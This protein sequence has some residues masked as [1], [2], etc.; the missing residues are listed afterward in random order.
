[1]EQ[2]N[3]GWGTTQEV[4][5]SSAWS[6]TPGTSV[7]QTTGTTGLERNQAIANAWDNNTPLPNGKIKFEK[8]IMVIHALDSDDKLA[9]QPGLVPGIGTMSQLNQQPG[10]SNAP[11]QIGQLGSQIGSGQ[12]QLGQITNQTQIGGP[13]LGQSQLGGLGQLGKY[14]MRMTLF[15]FCMF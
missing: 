10:L 13:Q 6:N 9:D 1:M 2:N 15:Y 7:G 3:S 5:V 11:N 4:P 8:I 14:R 12:S